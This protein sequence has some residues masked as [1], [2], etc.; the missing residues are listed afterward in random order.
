MQVKLTSFAPVAILVFGLGLC[1]CLPAGRSQL[2]EEKESHYLAGKSRASALDYEGALE[3]YEKAIEANPRSALAHFEAGL[4]CEKKQDHA[5]AIYHFDRFLRLKSDSQYSV[6]VNQRILACKAELAKG[7][8]LSPINQSLQK[9]FEQLS[10]QNKMYREE[11]EAWRA[12]ARAQTIT[13]PP[14]SPLGSSGSASSSLA[15]TPAAR[16]VLTANSTNVARLAA[17]AV[18]GRTHTVKSGDTPASI[19]RKY[20]VKLDILMAANPRVDARRLHVGQSLN[21]PSQ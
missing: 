21:V 1:G 17:M 14:I 13:N 20:G 18:P 5:A 4:L 15:A 6:L 7:V 9:E 10:Q 2:D 16:P 8:L 11:I 12:K 3:C 19:A